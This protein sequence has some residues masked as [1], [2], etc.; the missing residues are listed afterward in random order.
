MLWALGDGCFGGND[1]IIRDE[2]VCEFSRKNCGGGV[3]NFV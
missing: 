3:M 1:H 2:F